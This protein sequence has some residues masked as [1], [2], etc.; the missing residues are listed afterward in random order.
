MDTTFFT[1][2]KWHTW[3]RIWRTPVLG[4][5]SVAVM[6]SFAFERQMRLSSPNM[7][8][9]YPK[10]AYKFITPD[11][12][13]NVLKL[14]RLLDRDIFAGW[15]DRLRAATGRVPTLVIWGD[16]DP[17]IQPSFAGKFGTE[18]VHHFSDCGHWPMLEKPAGV[19]DLLAKHFSG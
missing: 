11:M 4:E 5:L 14:Y 12:K 1:D 16:K 13:R 7:P 2:Y 10:R 19:A 8:A 18:N 17:Y 6:N 15:E 9:G 3:G